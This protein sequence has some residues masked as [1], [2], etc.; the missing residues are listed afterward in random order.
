MLMGK[1]SGTHL[2]K[3]SWQAFWDHSTGWKRDLG[4]ERGSHFSYTDAQSFVPALDERLDIPAETREQSSY[5]EVSFV[6]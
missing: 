1:E 4:L 5:P 6:R 3:P 2:N